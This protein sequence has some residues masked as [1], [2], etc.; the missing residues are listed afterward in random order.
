M[1]K[2]GKIKK[3]RICSYYEKAL[4]IFYKI[5]NLNSKTPK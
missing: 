3:V 4:N 1:G 5:A 2:M